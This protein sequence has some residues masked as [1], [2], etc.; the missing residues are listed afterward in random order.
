MTTIGKTN[1]T[2]TGKKD[3]EGRTIWRGPRGAL[4]VQK[5]GRNVQVATPT[6][7][8]AAIRLTHIF[9][10]Y[11]KLQRLNKEEQKDDTENYMSCTDNIRSMA[12]VISGLLA[13]AVLSVPV[14]PEVETFPELVGRVVMITETTPPAGD[15]GVV[16]VKVREGRV[17]EAPVVVTNV[18]SK[19][20]GKDVSVVA[21]DFTRRFGKDSVLITTD[22]ASP[23]PDRVVIMY[24]AT[25]RLVAQIFVPERWS[26]KDDRPLR[27]TLTRMVGL[28]LEPSS[29]RTNSAGV[30]LEPPTATL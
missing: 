30:V 12:L 18:Q 23:D 19:F 25:T 29:L 22:A 14:R 4:F 16:K 26:T 1:K 2:N 24:D 11:T 20:V 7:A 13:I 9:L 15:D 5:N 17:V 10:E 6:T 8:R 28:R 27:K 3:P 21:A